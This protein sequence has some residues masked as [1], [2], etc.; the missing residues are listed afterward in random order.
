[1][2]SR[3]NENRCNQSAGPMKEALREDAVR[4]A[5]PIQSLDGVK[6][7]PGT[8]FPG[9]H[10]GY[11]TAHVVTPNAKTGLLILNKPLLR[12]TLVVGGP[13]LGVH[14]KILELPFPTLL[15]VLLRVASSAPHGLVAFGEGASLKQIP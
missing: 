2:S 3:S 14:L 12:P 6:R 8:L 10:L 5:L 9:F 1:M 15:H 4:C 11:T 13:E 7:N